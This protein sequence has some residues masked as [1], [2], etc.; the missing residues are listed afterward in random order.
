MARRAALDGRAPVERRLWESM[1]SHGIAGVFVDPEGVV[2]PES[3]RRRCSPRRGTALHHAHLSTRDFEAI[4]T[5][6]AESVGVCSTARIQKVD[7]KSVLHVLERAGRH[8]ADITNALLVG[9]EVTECQLDE[10]WSFVGKKEKNLGPLELLRGE[11]GDAWIWI[12]F[13]AVS[14]VVLASVIGKRTLTNA[15]SLLEDVRRVTSKMPTLFSSDQLQQ[16]ETALLTVY[17]KLVRP[18]RK[19]GPGRPPKARLEP[20]D[21]LLYVQVV[22]E[23]RENRVVKVDRKIVFGE[24]CAVDVVFDKSSVSQK[25]NTSGVERNNGTVRHMDARCA[26]KTYRFSKLMRNH[27]RQLDLSLAYYHLCRPHRSLS[28][29]HQR[30]TTPF[31]AIGITDIGSGSL[32]PCGRSPS[33]HH[34][35]RCRGAPVRMAAGFGVHLVAHVTG[36]VMIRVRLAWIGHERAVVVEVLDAVFVEVI[37]DAIAASLF[38]DAVDEPR[39]L[40]ATDLARISAVI[41]ADDLEAAA[42]FAVVA[43]FAVVVR[44]AVLDRFAVLVNGQG[45]AGHDVS[46][47]AIGA[48]AQPDRHQRLRR[49]RYQCRMCHYLCISDHRRTDWY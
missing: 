6:L 49:R 7:K 17:G 40:V 16:Y 23:Y 28:E 9:V 3:S 48:L 11:L 2:I 13:D 21:D 26:R 32:H 38:R 42:L 43:R 22:K 8:A 37:G 39:H 10:M 15:V 36:L 30:P 31:M 29:R 34:S 18:P 45:A 24:P 27:Q 1:T 20:P 47:A 12:A 41:I 19:P 5:S 35:S 44:F 46:T 25:I 33:V 4:A 14:K